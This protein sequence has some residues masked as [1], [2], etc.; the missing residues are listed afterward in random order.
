[1][2][3]AQ[4]FVFS[5]MVVLQLSLKGLGVGCSFDAVGPTGVT[6]AVQWDGLRLGDAKLSVLDVFGEVDGAAVCAAVLHFLHLCEESFGHGDVDEGVHASVQLFEGF[7]LLEVLGEVVKNEAVR[8]NWLD[9]EQFLNDFLLC[10]TVRVSCVNHLLDPYEELVIVVLRLARLL[11]N[12]SQHV[13]DIQH[14]N[15]KINSQSKFKSL[16]SVITHIWAH[17]EPR[18]R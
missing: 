17:W 4:E 15:P 3:K 2:V 16:T 1:M 10:E 6:S 13:L 5:G 18:R 8:G 7:G 9:S 11:S 14:W 12:S